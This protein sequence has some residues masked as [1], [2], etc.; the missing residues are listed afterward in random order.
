MLSFSST[1]LNQLHT[2]IYL[3]ITMMW[4]NENLHRRAKLLFLQKT[5]TIPLNHAKLSAGGAASLLQVRVTDPASVTSPAGKTVMEVKW[6]GS[7]GH[8]KKTWLVEIKRTI[9][10]LSFHFLSSICTHTQVPGR[11]EGTG[12]S[13][14]GWVDR[15]TRQR[16][17]GRSDWWSSTSRRSQD[18]VHSCV[19]NISLLS[20]GVLI[21][22][23]V[24]LKCN[25]P[26]QREVPSWSGTSSRLTAY[27][28]GLSKSVRVGVTGWMHLDLKVWTTHRHTHDDDQHR[29]YRPEVSA[30]THLSRRAWRCRGT[31]ICRAVGPSQT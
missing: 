16:V 1:G 18:S 26:V 4:M 11:Q 17:G 19:Q 29:L 31:S 30:W 12:P 27:K 9:Q 24:S 5:T 25:T 23:R 15:C 7:A 14:V 28:H 6:G 3:W 8:K 20:G 2:E 22:V 10:G 21:G 13:V